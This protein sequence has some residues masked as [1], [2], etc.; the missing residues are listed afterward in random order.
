MTPNTRWLLAAAIAAQECLE[1][2]IQGRAIHGQYELFDI[3]RNLAAAIRAVQQD[4]QDRTTSTKISR[5]GGH[6]ATP[7]PPVPRRPPMLIREG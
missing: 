4:E 3:G 6:E 5:E 2:R 7:R 1:R